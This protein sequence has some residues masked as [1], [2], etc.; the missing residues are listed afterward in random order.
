MHTWHT[1][2]TIDV[3]IWVT[4]DIVLADLVLVYCFLQVAGLTCAFVI[5][6][7]GVWGTALYALVGL[8]VVGLGFG[9]AGTG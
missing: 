2:S 4:F 1:D 8:G 3:G 9:A 5:S 6:Y 7:L